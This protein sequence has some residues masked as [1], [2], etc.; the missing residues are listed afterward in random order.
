MKKSYV[1][2]RSG[3]S[4]SNSPNNSPRDWFKKRLSLPL[5]R[6]KHVDFD[7]SS[8]SE[9]SP[10][11]TFSDEIDS[12]SP[13]K[14]NNGDDLRKVIHRTSQRSPTSPKFPKSPRS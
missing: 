3:N 1:F 14:R 2:S 11:V 8:S 7:Q 12:P 9:S 4:S 10:R 13:P 6:S 5:K